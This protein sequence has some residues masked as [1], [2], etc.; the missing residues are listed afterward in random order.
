MEKHFLNFQLFNYPSKEAD[1]FNT[2]GQ[3]NSH[4]LI[5]S[6]SELANKQADKDFI[7]NV[8]KAAKLSPLETHATLANSDKKDSA[9]AAIQLAKAVDAHTIIIFGNDLKALGIQAQLPAYQ[10]IEL[11]KMNLLWVH[12]IQTIRE[13]RAANKNEKAA[14]L[15]QALKQKFVD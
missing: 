1:N 4:I 5:I 2:I 15:W 11:N 12:S 7:E 9:L 14:A 6:H 10:F 13:E 3:G 8:F